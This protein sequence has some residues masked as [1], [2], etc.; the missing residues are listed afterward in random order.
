MLVMAVALS[1]V[2]GVRLPGGEVIVTA[3]LQLY[4]LQGSELRGPGV[5]HSEELY[6]AV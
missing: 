6:R 1:V 3:S 4:G 2:A 5:G